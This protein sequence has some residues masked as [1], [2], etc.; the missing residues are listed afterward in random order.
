MAQLLTPQAVRSLFDR[1]RSDVE[2]NM[3]QAVQD[4]A[5]AMAAEARKDASVGS[6]RKGSR[7]PARRGSTGPSV[8]SGRLRAEVA[9]S[10]VSRKGDSASATIG[11]RAAYAKFVS[12]Q[13]Y[14]FLQPA[15]RAVAK[16]PL[17]QIARSDLG[18]RRA[19]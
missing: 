1:L 15:G 18:R 17:R 16:G 13:G 2:Q 9:A 4:G 19:L 7:T 3:T 12:A 10:A 11:S 6:H 8:V 5:A 14:Q